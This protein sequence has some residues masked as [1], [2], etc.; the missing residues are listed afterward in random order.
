MPLL[1]LLFLLLLAFIAWRAYR[2]F[3]AAKS[4]SAAPPPLQD[5]VRCAVCD[6]HVPARTAL[7]EDG[8]S[9]CSEAHRSQDVSGSGKG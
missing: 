7:R 1:R 3:F 6:V 4:A 8:K 9:F 2:L 5:M